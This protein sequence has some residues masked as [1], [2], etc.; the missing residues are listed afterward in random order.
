MK[1]KAK[2]IIAFFLIFLM[3]SPCFAETFHLKDGSVVQGKVIKKW[4]HRMKQ[5]VYLE[6][7]YGRVAIHK[8]DILSGATIYLKD[9]SVVKGDIEETAEG[10][11][12][13]ETSYGEVVLKEA[14]IENI[15]YEYEA[16]RA[17]G[18]DGQE[19][20]SEED[21]L[22]RY[23]MQEKNAGLGFLGWLLFPSLGHAF[24]GEWGRGVP[25]LVVDIIG[26]VL[27][28][29]RTSTYHYSG[30]PYYR[31]YYTYEPSELAGVGIGLLIITRL[32]ELI[33]VVSY[34]NNFNR[35]L[36]EKYGLAL[37]PMVGF[38]KATLALSYEF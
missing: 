38:D 21:A 19:K 23:K 35:E 36:R 34:A 20:L 17:G 25:F 28:V 29:Q 9:G 4:K 22:M 10:K 37:K 27:A 7:S 6:T 12:Y 31:R 1:K 5:R 13:L 33:D 11:I 18:E 16:K 3:V 24:I 30:Y 2:G 8:A 26:Y 15:V 32:W 14:D